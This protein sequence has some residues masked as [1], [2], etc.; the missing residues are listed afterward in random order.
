MVK[1]SQKFDILANVYL[2][3]LKV[4]PYVYIYRSK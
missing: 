1:I 3:H 2:L 4:K